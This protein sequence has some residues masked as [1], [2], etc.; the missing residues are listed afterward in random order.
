M[1][2]VADARTALHAALSAS[3]PFGAASAWRVHRYVPETIAAPVAYIDSPD[4]STL[5]DSNG[6][7]F[8]LI[9]LPVVVIVD[10]L[11]R[12][13]VE[14]L[15]DALAAVW[16]AAIAAGGE[17]AAARAVSLDVGGPNLRA[18]IVQAEFTVPARTLCAEPVLGATA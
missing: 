7:T 15:D 18:Q 3:G 11:E 5:V 12:R 17:P 2:A 6:V 1:S 10:G 13:Q 14:Q 16:D 8:V 9:T 4:L